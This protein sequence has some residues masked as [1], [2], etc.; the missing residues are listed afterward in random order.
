MGQIGAQQAK[1]TELKTTWVTRTHRN[2][3]FL[4]GPPDDRRGRPGSAELTFAR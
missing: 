1:Y 2:G 4:P 3:A